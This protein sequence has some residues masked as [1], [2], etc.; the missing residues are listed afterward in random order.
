MPLKHNGTSTVATLILVLYSTREQQIQHPIE[1]T[2]NSISPN[3]TLLTDAV[4]KNFDKNA[5]TYGLLIMLSP[6]DCR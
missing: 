5:A 6:D 3:V 4:I 1:S 2:P